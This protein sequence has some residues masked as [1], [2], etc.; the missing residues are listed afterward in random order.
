MGT[1]AGDKQVPV[2]CS[3]SCVLNAGCCS[4]SGYVQMQIG[5]R[6]KEWRTLFSSL[7]TSQSHITLLQAGTSST[8]GISASMM[9][10]SGTS[11]YKVVVGDNGGLKSFAWSDRKVRSKL[12]ST[13]FHLNWKVVG[14]LQCNFNPLA[15]QRLNLGML[16]PPKHV[17]QL[18]NSY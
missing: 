13:I 12:L 6:K 3:N 10:E 1:V 7:S 16:M 9:T 8:G 4:T 14:V 11:G 18:Q 15:V 2:V 5:D 17:F